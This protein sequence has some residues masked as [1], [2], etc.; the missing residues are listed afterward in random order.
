MISQMKAAVYCCKTYPLCNVVVC[1]WSRSGLVGERH[2]MKYR[3]G[4]EVANS[5]ETRIC[6]MAIAMH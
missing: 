5:H 3:W 2:A 4:Q 1:S 6:S